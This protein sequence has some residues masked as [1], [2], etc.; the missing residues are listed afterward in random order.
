[1][2]ELKAK[3][4]GEKFGKTAS[5]VNSALCE[6]GLIKKLGKGYELCELGKNIGGTQAQYKG[7]N[8]VKWDKKILEN[9]VF[10]SAFSK[11]L[12]PNEQEQSETEKSFREKFP[13][14]IRTKSGHLV[15]S[16]AEQI[17]ADYLFSEFIAF[18]YEKLLPIEE[19]IF[20]DFYIP[21]GKIYIEFWG[22]ENDENYKRRKAE[23]QEIY[24]KYGFNLIEIDDKKIKNLDDFL[25]KELLKF[26]FKFA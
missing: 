23:K 19:N 1:M 22:L 26:G 15:R 3:E 14:T 2:S 5:E 12:N 13:A 7:I 6:L 11:I 24:K 18:A 9:K 10:L 8:F 16:R 25:P 4:I 21:K 17:I 20:C